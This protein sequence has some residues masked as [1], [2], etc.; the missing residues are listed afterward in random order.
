MLAA[1]A[2]VVVAVHRR[3]VEKA[4]NVVKEVSH[5]SDE[6][7]LEKKKNKRKKEIFCLDHIGEKK[8]VYETATVML[9]MMMTTVKLRIK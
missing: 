7:R 3:L 4:D 9:L 5:T 8:N 2:V 1:A 6:A